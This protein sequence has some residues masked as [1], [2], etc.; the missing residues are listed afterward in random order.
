MSLLDILVQVTSK[1]VCWCV[2][3]PVDGDVTVRDEELV[4]WLEEIQ[5][6]PPSI[7]RVRT[8]TKMDDLIYYRT[9]NFEMEG[10]SITAVPLSESV[11]ISEVSWF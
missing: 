8:C 2:T 10:N 7:Q 6:D 3:G 1:F 4:A 11:L 9:A 5:L